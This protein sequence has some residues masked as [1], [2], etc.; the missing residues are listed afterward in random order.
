MAKPK[1]VRRKP[2]AERKEGHLSIRARQDHLDEIAD[3]A[4]HVGIGVSAWAMERLLRC[5]RE[6]KR[7]RELDR[8]R[9]PGHGHGEQGEKPSEQGEKPN[10]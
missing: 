1:I 9:G 3:A 6:E 4:K 5:A 8:R 2:A 10:E 7:Q